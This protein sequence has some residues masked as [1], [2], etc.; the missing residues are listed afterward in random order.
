VALRHLPEISVIAGIGLGSL[1]LVLFFLR[2]FYSVSSFSFNA[3]IKD[4]YLESK[5]AESLR[6]VKEEFGRV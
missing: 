4:Q 6:I 2:Y 1:I 5:D 3:L